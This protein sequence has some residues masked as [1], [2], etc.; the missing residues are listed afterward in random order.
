MNHY[1][2]LSVGQ[3]GRV[4]FFIEGKHRLLCL[5]FFEVGMTQVIVI[6]LC[7][8]LYGDNP[9]A[10]AIGLSSVQVDNHGTTISY[11]LNQCKFCTL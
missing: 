11:H 9:Q 2:A 5:L 4:R 10:F 1:C 3:S 8:R 6:P 7:A